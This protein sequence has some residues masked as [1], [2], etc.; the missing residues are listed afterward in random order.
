ML[1]IYK[2]SA[3]SG[4][5]FT[6]A[7]QYIKML[8]G[9]RLADGRYVLNHRRYLGR[10]P[11]SRRHSH[12]LA[13]TFTNKAT[14]EMKQRILDELFALTRVPAPG[15][16][17]APYAAMLIAEF[18]CSREDLATTAY[19][20][21]RQLLDDYGSFNVST[22]DAFFQTV[23]RSFAREIERQGDYRLELQPRAVIAQAM[24]M[25]F[26]ELNNDPSDP[27]MARVAKW[28]N[29]MA[30]RRLRRGA[31]FNPFNRSG[32]M[33]GE[34]FGS[35]ESTFSEAFMEH[36]EAVEAYMA[37]PERLADF[38][39]WLDKE[40]AGCQK[41]IVELLKPRLEELTKGMNT[42]PAGFLVKV[43]KAGGDPE[44]VLA[45]VGTKAEPAYRQAMRDG[46]PDGVYGKKAP[47]RDALAAELGTIVSQIEDL[48]MRAARYRLYRE[49]T[50]ALWSL[51]FIHSYIERFRRENNMI[52]LADT[53]TLLGS[54]ISESDTPFIYEKVGVELHNF[55]I[56]EFQDTSRMQW[57][58]LRPLLANSLGEDRDSL[59]IGD[60]KQSI[61]RWRGGDS[62]LLDHSVEN[63]DFP[64]PR[65]R[66]KGSGPGENT[67]YRSAH[68]LVK[69]NNTLFHSLASTYHIAGYGGIAQTPAPKME[70]VEGA[71]RI[72]DF[73]GYPTGAEFR[74]LP[75]YPA[76][77]GKDFDFD[78]L[79]GRELSLAIMGRRIL[80]QHRR[81]YRFSDMAILCRG[82]KDTINVAEFLRSHFPE[83]KVVSEEGLL[84]INSSAVKMI[85]SMLE[86]I[87][88]G[89][90][91]RREQPRER[92]VD[93]PREARALERLEAKRDRDRLSDTF[94]FHLA[95]GAPVDEALRMALDAVTKNAPQHKLD[96]DIE[97]LRQIAPSNLAALIEA[98]IAL[99]IPAEQR[100][101]EVAY[102]S[103]FVD[104]AADYA[105][106]FTPS[107]HAFLNYWRE[108]GS[109]LSVGTSD[110][111]DAVN[112]MTVHKA[113]GLEWDCVHIPLMNWEFT[114]RDESMWMEMRHDTSLPA[115]LVPEV[116][117]LRSAQCMKESGSPFAPLLNL[118]MA[119]GIADNLN[120]AYVAFTRAVR[121]LDIHLFPPSKKHADGVSM[122]E[123]LLGALVE[124]GVESEIYCDISRLNVAPGYYAAGEPTVPLPKK[125]KADGDALPPP[126]FNV[127]FNALN[128]RF[129]RLEDLTTMA[130]PSDDPDLGNEVDRA[131][132]D[133]PVA[134]YVEAMEEAARRGLVMHSILSQMYDTADLHGA[135]MRHRRQLSASEAARFE[136]EVEEAFAKAGDVAREWFE[137]KAEKVLNEQA[138]YDA[139]DGATR[140][141]DRIVFNRDGSIDVVDYKFTSR[142]RKVHVEQ[143][144]R[145]MALL[146]DI[147]PGRTIRGAL[148][149]PLLGLVK[150]V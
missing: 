11:S 67:N 123:A 29:D 119:E 18:G 58:N 89:L 106:N 76:E 66:V 146:G 96:S 126:E 115:H 94:N 77:G 13:V 60:V 127:S 142:P 90:F 78:S 116:M 54:I 12:I 147:Y 21:F 138:I 130:E 1:T 56:D 79:E 34:I 149:Y 124:G 16:K 103:A 114:P 113:K 100:A 55:L 44:V 48:A 72:L 121:E 59:I 46:K 35:V 137:P 135:V 33:Y 52:L 2:A 57:R 15:E 43:V 30:G 47:G 84:L 134:P 145:Y 28:L 102:I 10:R 26:D 132:V 38:E 9:E 62:N 51:A 136:A 40:V 101:R 3:G 95:E 139:R 39:G 64:A 6:L 98:I 25:L 144:E 117:Y 111:I 36:R 112:I 45:K 81:G 63:V 49:S 129:T 32:S 31:D 22:I 5:T 75:G 143:V 4:K 125:K 17:D 65:S 8:L 141:V 99:K 140:R 14:A 120:V 87:D 122:G 131:I 88:K 104:F 148:W 71:L 105:A 7:L 82:V 19:A 150:K 118:R 107:V 133:T 83:I 73:I 108:F 23:L 86:I 27:D 69:F 91:D 68:R 24:S 97:R 41:S 20:A 128:S 50:T 85:V 92:V 61:Y 37:T 42:N 109:R 74:E 70:G 80:D 110:R 53:N 93:D